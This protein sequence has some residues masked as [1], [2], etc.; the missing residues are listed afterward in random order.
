MCKVSD[1]FKLCTC[2]TKNVQGLKHY[3]VLKRPT[4]GLLQAVGELVMPANIGAAEDKFN[5]H[6]ILTLL[7]KENCFDIELKHQ[8]KDTLQLHFTVKENHEKK[9]NIFADGSYLAYAFKFKNGKWIA[10]ENDPFDDNFN[11]I[12]NGEISN[13]LERS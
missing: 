8:E 1:Q 7:N 12:K 4:K 3:W 6:L 2:I 10:N 11:K 5:K 13:A 9:S